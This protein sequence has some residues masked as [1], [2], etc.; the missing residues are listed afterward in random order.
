M[1]ASTD[2]AYQMNVAGDANRRLVIF[3]D[4]SMS[5]G[6]GASTRDTTLF[7]ESASQLRTDGALRVGTNI[8][9]GTPPSTT[10]RLSVAN[11]A[12][13]QMVAITRTSTSDSSPLAVIL[14]GDTSTAQALGIS[15]NGDTTN[16]FG[17]DPTGKVSW[18]DG[19]ASRDTNLYRSNPAVLKTDGA[20][21]ATTSIRLNTTSL[22]SGV[23]VVAMAN[24]TTV[25]TGT[26]SGGG[27][28]YVE[29]GAL[30]YKGSSGTVTTIAAA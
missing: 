28:L 5:W 23:G 24:A 11:S 21:Q 8:G 13:G 3:A 30:K 12:A 14:A 20:L 6:D 7:R 10:A 17:I 18:G 19:T 9:V 16:R 22:G 4:G 2:R 27:V 15:V 1:T 29:A 26:P 25:P